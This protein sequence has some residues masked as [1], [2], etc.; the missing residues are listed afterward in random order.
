M[1]QLV[2]RNNNTGSERVK[3]FATYE[4]AFAYGRSEYPGSHWTRIIEVAE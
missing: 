4:A 3:L 2:I 1:Y